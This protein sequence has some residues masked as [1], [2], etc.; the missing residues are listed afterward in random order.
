MPISQKGEASQ[1][2]PDWNCKHSLSFTIAAK[3]MQ[4]R[5]PQS[6]VEA[7]QKDRCPVIRFVYMCF[8]KPL[9]T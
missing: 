8:D 2:H 7:N 6:K 3:E 1:L 5:W 9:L 4:L